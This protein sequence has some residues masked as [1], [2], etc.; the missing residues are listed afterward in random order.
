MGYFDKKIGRDYVERHEYTISSS[1]GQSVIKREQ[2]PWSN[3]IAKF[4]AVSWGEVVK[5][6]AVLTSG[7]LQL[8]DWSGARPARRCQTVRM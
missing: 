8:C 3:S 6:G 5:K 1:D 2:S 4:D 7:K